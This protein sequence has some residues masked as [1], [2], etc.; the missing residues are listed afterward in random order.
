MIEQVFA[1]IL[2]AKVKSNFAHTIVYLVH[3]NGTVKS[4]D[5]TASMHCGMQCRLWISLWLTIYL[6]QFRYTGQR[7]PITLMWPTQNCTCIVATFHVGC[8]NYKFIIFTIFMT[9]LAGH[10]PPNFTI[11]SDR[12]EVGLISFVQ[13]V[14]RRGIYYSY[15]RMLFKCVAK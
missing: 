10:A 11:A 5:K 8:Y 1:S 4:L 7:H 12:E 13:F 15:R 9:N 6:R 3:E 2:V 14:Q